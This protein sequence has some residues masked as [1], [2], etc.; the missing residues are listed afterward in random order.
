MFTTSSSYG[1][2]SL[3]SPTLDVSGVAPGGRIEELDRDEE[4]DEGNEKTPLIDSGI[5][6]G[7]QS[8]NWK[9]ITDEKETSSL[10]S[11]QNI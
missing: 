4:E 2:G 10:Y 1:G 3:K 5:I 9:F 7:P 8:V 11:K 6:F